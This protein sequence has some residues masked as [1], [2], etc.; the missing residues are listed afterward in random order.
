MK[1]YLKKNQVSKYGTRFEFS[2]ENGNIQD[3]NFSWEEEGE[4]F[5]YHQELYDV[6]TIEREANKIRLICIK[7]N[8]ENQLENQINEIHKIDKTGNSKNVLN[9]IKFF[10]VFYLEKQEKLPIVEKEMKEENAF[11]SSSLLTTFIDIPLLPPRYI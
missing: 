6:V 8:S 3:D 4:E 7:D 10:S 1:A 11:C 9:N 2:L 5:R